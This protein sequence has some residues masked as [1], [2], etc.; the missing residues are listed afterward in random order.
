METNFTNY[1]AIDNKVSQNKID[2]TNINTH[3]KLSQRGYYYFTNVLKHKNQ[4]TVK[5]PAVNKNPYSANDNS[6]LFRITLDGN[7]Q[8]IYTDYFK[9]CSEFIIHD[10]TN[11]IDLFKSNII[12]H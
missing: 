10:Q 3:I 1:N 5:F 2:I 6:E 9:N 11:G 12:G 8:I 4:F 7:Y